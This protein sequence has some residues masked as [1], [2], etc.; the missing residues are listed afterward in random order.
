MQGQGY[1]HILSDLNPVP[2]KKKSNSTKKKLVD[3]QKN[4]KPH[5]NCVSNERSFWNK[6]G[7]ADLAKRRY[8]KE[9][10]REE[11]INFIALAETGRENF[12]DETLQN[13]CGGRDFIW[14]SMA[15]HGRSGGM[16]LGIDLSIYDIG[17]I[18]EDD[19]YVKFCLRNKSDGFKFALYTVYGLGQQQNKEAFLIELAHTCSR[20]TLCVETQKWEV[21]SIF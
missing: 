13:Y 3:L 4:Q 7:L 11:Q 18:D 12:P 21:S 14:H 20:E 9:M 8:L 17:S 16:L 6:R 2:R 1:D 19:F 10:V 15:P 5:P